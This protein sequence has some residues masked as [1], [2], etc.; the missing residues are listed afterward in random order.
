MAPF[1]HFKLT[2]CRWVEYLDQISI[3]GK[4]RCRGTEPHSSSPL[5]RGLFSFAGLL[6]G[7]VSRGVWR[8]YAAGP[9]HR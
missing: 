7:Q 3:S 9:T 6:L 8:Y 4:E 2:L 5:T 1:G